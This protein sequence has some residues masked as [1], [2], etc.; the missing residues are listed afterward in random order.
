MSK[1]NFVQMS[2]E[3]RSLIVNDLDHAMVG[4][5][6]AAIEDYQAAMIQTANLAMN[7][8]A[9]PLMKLGR[10]AERRELRYNTL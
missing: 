3:R 4:Q 1:T 6:A 9:D 7:N 5:T 2:N 8:L 10:N